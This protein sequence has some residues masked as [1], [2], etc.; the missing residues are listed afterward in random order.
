MAAR[1]AAAAMKDAG[2]LAPV[3][4]VDGW[5]AAFMGTS[6]VVSADG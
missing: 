1:A 3:L 2:P 6:P 4:A 5:S